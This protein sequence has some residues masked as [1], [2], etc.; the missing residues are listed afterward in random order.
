M[1]LGLLELALDIRLV[2]GRLLA[3]R[4]SR[5]RPVERRTVNAINEVFREGNELV[6]KAREFVPDADS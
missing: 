3:N 4:V 1:S 2:I 6:G 5:F